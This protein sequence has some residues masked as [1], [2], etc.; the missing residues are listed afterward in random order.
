MNGHWHAFGEQ[1]ASYVISKD[2][3]WVTDM[4]NLTEVIEI[5]NRSEEISAVFWFNSSDE[6]VVGEIDLNKTQIGFFVL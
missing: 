4:K 1:A 5:A 6:A 2:I 3:F